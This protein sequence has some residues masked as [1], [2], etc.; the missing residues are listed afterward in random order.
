MLPKGE[1]EEKKV[2][3]EEDTVVEQVSDRCSARELSPMPNMTR[4]TLP[5]LNI[6]L[7]FHFFQSLI[8]SISVQLQQVFVDA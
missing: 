2:A 6:A 5:L 7:Y 3:E 1:K 8:Y 4:N